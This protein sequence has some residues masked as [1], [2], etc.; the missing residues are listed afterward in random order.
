MTEKPPGPTEHARWCPEPNY[1]WQQ[2]IWPTSSTRGRCV[3]CGAVR[4]DRHDEPGARAR[5]RRWNES[6]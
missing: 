6:A 5:T 3:H 2:A 1:E 4:I